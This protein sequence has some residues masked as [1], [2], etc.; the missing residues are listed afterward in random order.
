MGFYGGSYSDKGTFVAQDNYLPNFI[1][2]AI[3]QGR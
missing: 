2:P 3:H 1:L